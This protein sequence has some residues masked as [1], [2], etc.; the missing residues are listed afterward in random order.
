MYNADLI[1]P[2]SAYRTYYHQNMDF[3]LEVM[4]MEGPPFYFSIE[5]KP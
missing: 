4:Q 5:A 3:Y 2:K 1:N